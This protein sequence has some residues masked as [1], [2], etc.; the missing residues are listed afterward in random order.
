MSLFIV[1]TPIG[2]FEDITYRAVRVLSEVDLIASEDTRVTGILLKHYDIKKTQTSY[3]KFNIKTKTDYL[4]NLLKEGK[5]IALVSDAG[6]P[7]ISDPGEELVKSAIENNIEV[8]PIPG[9]SGIITAL[10]VSGL[11]TKSFSF[12]GFL[13]KK[14][15]KRKKLLESL[16]EREETI[17]IYESPYRLEKCLHDII[18]ELGDREVVVG[19]ELTKKFEE[20]IRG[21][22]SKVLVHFQTKKAKG[23]VIVLIQGKS[24]Q[25][26]QREG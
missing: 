19:R 6:T 10:S 25:V 20:F 8:I 3:H 13:P 2:N 4:I 18:E 15:G 9:P 5:S 26:T 17:V 16:K 24:C 1:A 11:S 7:G 12:Y 21:A 14:L 22:A 23:E